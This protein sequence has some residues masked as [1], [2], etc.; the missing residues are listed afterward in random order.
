MN[1]AAM[2]NATIWSVMFPLHTVLSIM[3]A[4]IINRI[5]VAKSLGFMGYAIVI[6]K[7]PMAPDAGDPVVYVNRKVMVLEL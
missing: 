7:F 2:A 6:A 3:H 1:Q 5:I 4:R